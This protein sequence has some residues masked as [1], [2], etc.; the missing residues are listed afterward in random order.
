MWLGVVAVGVA[1]FGLAAWLH[2][3]A[4]RLDE[5]LRALQEQ[6]EEDDRKRSS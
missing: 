5:E 6:A 4:V 3:R 2:A 1:F